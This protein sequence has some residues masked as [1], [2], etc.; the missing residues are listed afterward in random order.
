M[1]RFTWRAKHEVFLA[2]VD[3][4][5]RDLFRIADELH[6]A[7]TKGAPPDAVSEHLH[8]L[9]AYMA[10]HFP[11]E[12]ELMRVVCYPSLRWHTSQHTARKRLKLL[13]PLVEA[14]DRQAARLLFHFLACWLHDHTTLT[15]RMMAA[16]V[17]NHERTHA[18]TFVN[19]GY[20]TLALPAN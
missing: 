4:E 8:H 3:A 14:G 7:V 19:R 5:H 10:E 18:A 13:A 6:A 1:A 12:E 9:A 17:R 20:W 16:Y 2:P 11:H 15:D